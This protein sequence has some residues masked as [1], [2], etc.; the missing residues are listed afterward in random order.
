MKLH[1]NHTTEYRYTAPLRY[2]LQTLWLVPQSGPAQTVHFWSVGAPQKLFAQRDAFGNSVN[3]YTFVGQ[4]SGDV[5][6]SLVNAAGEVDTL[7]IAEFNDDASLPLPQLY[8][9]ATQL[10]QPH[11]LLAEFGRRFVLPDG[12]DGSADLSELLALSQGVAG[13]VSYQKYSTNVTTTALQAFE[14]GAGVCQDQ[15]HVMVAICRSLGIPARY[16]SG[17]FYAANEPDLA[18]H[19]W[20]DVCLDVA[21]RRWASIDVTHSCLIDERHVR[22]AMGTDYNACPPIK[23][24]RQGGGEESMTV[25]ITIEPV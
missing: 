17:Y 22:L 1:V 11:P 25:N 14:A 24:V 21:S 10:A 23:G 20:V 13:A 12:A 6:W 3:A 15:A 9:R 5:R 18:S 8:L 16:V 7:G 2:A 19:A 4:E